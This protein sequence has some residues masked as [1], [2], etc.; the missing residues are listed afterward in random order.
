MWILL[1]FFLLE[2]RYLHQARP[3]VVH[4]DL[5]MENVMLT[6]DHNEQVVAKLGDF[7]LHAVLKEPKHT[8]VTTENEEATMATSSI[9]RKVNR[10]ELARLG[11]Q[12]C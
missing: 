11:N 1:I 9:V 2:I 3:M 12:P 5:K 6:L 7:G 10:S 4:R 8:I